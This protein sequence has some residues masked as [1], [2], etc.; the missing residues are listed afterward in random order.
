[1]ICVGV[2]RFCLSWMVSCVVGVGILIWRIVL[3]GWVICLCWCG[4]GRSMIFV[5]CGKRLRWLVCRLWVSFL[6]RC[7]VGCLC[8]VRCRCG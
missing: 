2:I 1:M 8:G 7:L 6:L 5:G 3:S 4:C